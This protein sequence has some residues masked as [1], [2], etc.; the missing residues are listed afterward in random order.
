MGVATGMPRLRYA[1]TTTV[2]VMQNIQEG[3]I[4]N[5]LQ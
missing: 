5:L 4:I 3:L 1:A 2:A